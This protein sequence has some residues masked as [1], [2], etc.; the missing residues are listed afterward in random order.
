MTIQEIQELVSLFK[1]ILTGITAIVATTVA[2][3]GLQTWKKQLKGKAEY[4]LARRLLIATYK[5][6]DRIDTVRNPFVSA[7]EISQSIKEADIEVEFGEEDYH[8]KSQGAVYQR[9]W[10]YL[11]DAM[12]DL[13]VESL[14]AETIWGDEIVR[15]LKPIRVN[16]STLYSNILKYM[17]HL[18]APNVQI[19]PKLIEEMDSI[20][21]TAKK[22]DKFSSSL[23]EAIK[24]VE[25]YLRPHIKVI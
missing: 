10:K 7:S 14:E 17:Y 6:R 4:E 13:E 18:Q 24:Q 11:Q 12:R 25:D 3:L 2:V 5:V 23:H 8:A 9:R 1:D 20:I 15:L 19:D 21:Y 22:N 16:V